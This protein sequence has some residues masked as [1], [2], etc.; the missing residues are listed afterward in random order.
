MRPVAGRRRDHRPAVLDRGEER[1]EV[2]VHVCRRKV[3][4]D[5]A[6]PDALLGRGVLPHQGEDGVGRGVEERRVDDPLHAGGHRGVD[7]G[8]V[9]LAAGPRA[10]AADTR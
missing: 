8:E 10:S 2:G 5:A 4:A 1:H 7:G 6:L 3:C 9:L